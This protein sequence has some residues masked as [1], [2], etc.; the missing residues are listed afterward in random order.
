MRDPF[1]GPPTGGLTVQDGDEVKVS[2]AIGPQGVL[3]AFAAFN[4]HFKRPFTMLPI[5]SGTM[6][7]NTAGA[8]K[9]VQAAGPQGQQAIELQPLYLVI[10][11]AR[12][13]SQAEATPVLEAVQ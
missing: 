9:M 11:L 3:Q 7:I 1:L 8:G 13:R 12:P 2:M 6:P 10:A 5:F 4:E